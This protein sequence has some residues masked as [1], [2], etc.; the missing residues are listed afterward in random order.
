MPIWSTLWNLFLTSVGY[1]P[2]LIFLLFY[3]FH[4]CANYQPE[5][6]MPFNTFPSDFVLNSQDGKNIM[7]ICLNT[8][9]YSTIIQNTDSLNSQF[10]TTDRVF[11][12]L[13]H[14]LYSVHLFRFFLLV[15]LSLFS[16]SSSLLID[17][18]GNKI[19]Q[20]EFLAI[21]LDFHLHRNIRH[22]VRC[23]ILGCV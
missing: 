11:F 19:F 18:S 15:S 8:M 7:P 3:N 5:K 20:I 23:F 16:S 2:G 9:R 4:Q 14:F 12:L 1:K 10:H 21:K 17:W 13:I 22:L 6:W